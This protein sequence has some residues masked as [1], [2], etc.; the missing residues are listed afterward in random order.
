MAKKTY[1]R[2]DFMQS[3]SSFD[4]VTH[5]AYPDPLTL[6]Y[7]DLKL[8]NVPKKE[9]M[10]SNKIVFFWKVAENIYGQPV[11]DDV[12]LT[13]N[14]NRHKNLLHEGTTIY[15]PAASDIER[16]FQIKKV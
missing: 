15:F 13:L 14:G 2:Y 11:Y 9:E 6:N 10:T 4:P 7:F 8:N 1:S 3:G 12:V 16:S 5:T